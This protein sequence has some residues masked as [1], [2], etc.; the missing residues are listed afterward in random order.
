[1]Q[2]LVELFSSIFGDDFDGSIYTSGAD[3]AK[4]Q[5]GY[6]YGDG[7]ALAV[8]RPKN[9]EQISEILKICNERSIAIVPQGGNTGLVGSS[10]PDKSKTQIVISTELLNRD[11]FELDI[12]KKT[13]NVGAG[14]VL[15]ELN[16][17]IKDSG[18][19]LPVDIG[20]AGSCNIGGILATNAAGTRAARYG[21]AKA[22][23]VSY[24]A[25][26]ANG[27]IVEYDFIA[28]DS[29]D[30]QDNSRIDFANPIIGSQGTLGIILSAKLH[31]V[32]RSSRSE[33]FVIVPN[34]PQDIAAIS[35]YLSNNFG[36]SFTAFEGMNAEALR[37]VAKHIP[38]AKYLLE[39]MKN[40]PHALLVEIS[41]ADTN[42][43]QDDLQ[44]QIISHLE[45]IMNDGL[46]INGLYGKSEE[47]WHVRHHI[48]EALK[49]EGEVIAT[50]IAVKDPDRLHEFSAEMTEIMQENYPSLQVAIFG[51][52][53]LGALHF[54]LV[55]S[56]ENSAPFNSADK[57]FVQRLI[58][59]KITKKYD[60]TFSAEHGIGPHNQWAY[61]EFVPQSDKD[62]YDQLKQKRDPKNIMNPNVRY[63]LK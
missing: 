25:V 36:E 7:I 3:K 61:D 23:L 45:V 29:Q 30:M 46:V 5:R 54:N 17:K 55:H 60:G 14:L 47:Y 13:I 33:S 63:G 39:N 8:V 34:K 2:N 48:S 51:H 57:I 15:D 22:Q 21:S 44:E 62:K 40:A 24:C 12:A 53:M 42:T 50:D 11:L 16:E 18:L 10:T 38:N 59:E 56:K 58:Y 31:L 37:L 28:D 6:R 35:A 19:F 27:E 4:Y 49:K 32:Q 9:N 26:Y 41:S 20:S 52:E 43:N 1:M